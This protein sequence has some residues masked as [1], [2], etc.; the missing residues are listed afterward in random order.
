MGDKS[1][2]PACAWFSNDDLRH[3]ML[4]G[5]SKHSLYEI[6]SGSSNHIRPKFPRQ[7]KIFRQSRPW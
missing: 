6:F 2:K 4:A 7:R 3:I 1:P 5:N